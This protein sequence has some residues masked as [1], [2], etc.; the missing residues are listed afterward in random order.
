MAQ[1]EA[2][3]FEDYAQALRHAAQAECDCVFGRNDAEL[4][5]Q[6]LGNVQTRWPIPA[7]VAAL[8]PDD[9]PECACRAELLQGRAR[10]FEAQAC[11]DVDQIDFCDSPP[12]YSCGGGDAPGY[13]WRTHFCAPGDAE[14]LSRT[15]VCD[16]NVDCPDGSDERNC[17][18]N[19]TAFECDDGG[20]LPI[21]R[22]CDNVP[23]C[24]DVSDETRC[25][26]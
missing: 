25:G 7:C 21:T 3:V 6:C 17:T 8:A 9:A 1:P 4:Y 10:C 26:N 13:C 12:D 11:A 5:Q 22:V 24:A 15:K 20:Q 23:D 14:P 2:N 18:P 16:G 19:Q